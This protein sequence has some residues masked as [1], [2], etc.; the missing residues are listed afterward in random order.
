MLNYIFFNEEKDISLKPWQL[1]CHIASATIQKKREK[2]PDN[3]DNNTSQAQGPVGHTGAT[4][5]QGP[6][7]G[8]KTSA[9]KSHTKGSP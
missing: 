1:L 8:T 7:G 6:S 5:E 3:N 4:W 2:N 9:G